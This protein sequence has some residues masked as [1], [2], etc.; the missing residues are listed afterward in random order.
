MSKSNYL[1]YYLRQARRTSISGYCSS[2]LIHYLPQTHARPLKS[3][4]DTE[5]VS[6][7]SARISRIRCRDLTEDDLFAASV[8]SKKEPVVYVW[9]GCYYLDGSYFTPDSDRPHLQQEI[10]IREWRFTESFILNLIKKILLCSFLISGHELLVFWHETD[11]FSKS[12]TK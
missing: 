5:Q 11:L 1:M 2:T 3:G 9:S 4:T 12:L 10:L 8:K 6:V 7:L